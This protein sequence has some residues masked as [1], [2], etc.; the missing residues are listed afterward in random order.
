MNINIQ[1]QK[2]LTVFY[3]D[4]HASEVIVTIRSVSLLMNVR[5][6]FQLFP[7][8]DMVLLYEAANYFSHFMTN[9]HVH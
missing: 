2:Y 7:T 5:Y 8:F 1:P 3:Y 6:S 4:F 9:I